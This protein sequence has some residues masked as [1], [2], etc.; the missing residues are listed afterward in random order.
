MSDFLNDLEN[1]VHQFTNWVRSLRIPHIPGAGSVS[2]KREHPTM[3][4]IWLFDID[5]PA[6]STAP[7]WDKRL[8][9]ATVDGVAQPDIEV[10]PKEAPQTIDA[11]FPED[12]HVELTWEDYDNKG[13]TKG[14][15][16][17][18][19]FEVNDD[20]G[21]AVAG[22]GGVSNKREKPVTLP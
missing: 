3:A 22:V 1:I 17:P 19:A 5:H 16:A 2:N 4:D 14:A 6:A 15:S 18:F 7:D 21:P 11:E 13:N 8:V 9:H 12:S 20:V 10:A